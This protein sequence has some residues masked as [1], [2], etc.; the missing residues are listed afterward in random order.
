MDER[1]IKLGKKL[2]IFV[3]ILIWIEKIY[4]QRPRISKIVKV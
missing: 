1:A 4:Y 3:K 2:Q